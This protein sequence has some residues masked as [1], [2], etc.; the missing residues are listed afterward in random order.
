MS[1]EPGDI[2]LIIWGPN[3]G[4]HGTYRNILHTIAGTFHWIE[5]AEGGNTMLARESFEVVTDEYKP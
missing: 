1:I 4:K 3:R 2:V 5:L